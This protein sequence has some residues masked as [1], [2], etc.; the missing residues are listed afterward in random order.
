MTKM[1]NYSF[2]YET[3]VINELLFDQSFNKYLQ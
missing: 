3:F 2:N 1:I